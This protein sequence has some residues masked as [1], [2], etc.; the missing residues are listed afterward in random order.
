MLAEI[1]QKWDKTVPSSALNFR[2][3]ENQTLQE[4]REEFI[5]VADKLRSKVQLF[6][7]F[8]EHPTDFAKE[9]HLELASGFL[10][11]MLPKVSCAG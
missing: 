10:K 3:P 1:L 9:A 11:K 4:L 8:E 5:R 2:T 6:C 7:V